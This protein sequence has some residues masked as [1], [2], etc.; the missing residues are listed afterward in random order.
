[1]GFALL[2]WLVLLY[3][4]SGKPGWFG[5]LLVLPPR[6]HPH[7]GIRMSPSPVDKS[8]AGLVAFQ[9]KQ[10]K[11]DELSRAGFHWTGDISRC[12]R[13]GALAPIPA[14]RGGVIEPLESTEAVENASYDEGDTVFPGHDGRDASR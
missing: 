8:S 9:G 10:L 12:R 14:I 1:M 5:C 11:G 3:L 7:R 6:R 4:C 13:K 2:V